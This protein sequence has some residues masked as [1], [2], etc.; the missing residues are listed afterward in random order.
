MAKNE[1]IDA[2]VNIKTNGLSKAQSGIRKLR[3]NWMDFAGDLAEP[4][5]LLASGATKAQAAWGGLQGVFITRVLGPMGMVAGASAAMLAVAGS[6]VNKFKEMGMSGAAG[7]SRMT[8]EFRPLLGS[9]DLAR[10]RVAQLYKFTASTPFRLNGVVKANKTLQTLTGGMLATEAGMKLVGDSAAVA[11]AGIDETARSV[12]RLYDGLM[13]GRP[14]GEASMRLQ[15]LGLLSGRTR[16]AIESMQAANVSGLKVWSMVESELS[17]NKGAMKD[18]SQEL[19]GLQ[20]TLEDTQ[21]LALSGFSKGFM[22]GEKASVQASTAAWEKFAPVLE[23]VG[24]QLGTVSNAFQSFKAKIQTVVAGSNVLANALK[25]AANA[26]VVFNAAVLIAA[27]AALG[28]FLVNV[29]RLSV[30]T[31]SQISVMAADT[32]VKLVNKKATE[33]LARANV[34]LTLSYSNVKKGAFGAALAN[35]KLAVSNTI[36]AFKI[37]A[38][39]AAAG[40]CSGA[41]KLMGRAAIFA[42]KSVAAMAVALLANPI[43]LAV[44]AFL[45]L[46]AV[47]LHL[48]NKYADAE[49]KLNSYRRASESLVST[50][51]AQRSAIQ[52]VIDKRKQEARVLAELSNAYREEA[53]AKQAG[54]AL[55]ANI[56]NNKIIA[57][58]QELAATRELNNERL[59]NNPQEAAQEEDD[60]QDEKRTKEIRDSQELSRADADEKVAILKDRAEEKGREFD[61]ARSDIA[62]E[63][64]TDSEIE[65]RTGASADRKIQLRSEIGDLEARE[66]VIST[67]AAGYMMEGN[68]SIGRKLRKEKEEVDREL[69]AK[70]AELAAL[71]AD[72]GVAVATEV[73]LGSSSE[74]AQLKARINLYD[75]LEKAKADV[76]ATETAFSEA[77]GADKGED[78]YEE[79]LSKAGNDK[80]KAKA[81]L[82]ALT[83]VNDRFADSSEGGSVAPITSPAE[84]EAAKLDLARK[85]EERKVKGRKSGVVEAEFAAGNAEEDRNNEIAGARL[86]SEG[87]IAQ[88]RLKGLAAEERSLEIAREKLELARE[89]GDIVGEEY[90]AAKKALDARAGGLKE[91][92]AEAKGSLVNNLV[93]KRGAV[94]EKKARADGDLA[95]VKKAQDKQDKAADA[96][97]EKALRKEAERVSSNPEEIDN[98]VKAG[99]ETFKKDRK[100][101][102][103][104][105]EEAKE[106]GRD[107]TRAEGLG[108]FES[109]V[110]K[111]R[112]DTKGAAKNEEDRQRDLD[113]V[114]RK[115]AFKKY[116]ADGFDADEADEMAD[117][118][119][120]VGQAQRAMDQLKAEAGG[121]SVVASSLAKI[122]GG[123]G[124]SG[125]DPN[126]RILEKM[127]QLLKDIRDKDKEDV[128]NVF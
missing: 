41:F 5:L 106:L 38:T 105:E 53:A 73:G 20:S 100:F 95:G 58:R 114:K 87:V 32:T 6:L 90:V 35:M 77:A 31:K 42:G 94:E 86:D 85:V 57:L 8:L 15:E 45:A 29:L 40:L 125:K 119:V 107:K 62:A 26:F 51:K 111:A 56:A 89:S 103:D 48:R 78:D 12:G 59:K 71:E 102:R 50:L 55:A 11:G 33:M 60:Y 117:R 47:L 98:I 74:I 112:G 110:L 67:E 83:K 113:D 10:Q 127:E 88:Y 21:S 30:A 66:A 93:G 25:F 3:A 13:S 115:E 72:T 79:N 17:R 28:R 96:E 80:D 36:A 76:A 84:A 46:G 14:V 65:K 81:D 120:K 101:N 64:A 2:E 70:R 1:R 116:K 82:I 123:G 61:S 97:K 122:G 22:E 109:E 126:T 44:T 19:E 121:G 68:G 92:T 99:M 4:M 27:G 108:G 9:I 34:A 7:L 128:T 104:Q 23:Y 16:N 39:S 43:M 49:E 124:V 118:D 75:S 52:T 18:L 24:R 54:E 91:K 37:N 69:P 63:K